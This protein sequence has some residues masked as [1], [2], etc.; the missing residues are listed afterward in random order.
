MT[1]RDNEQIVSPH[2][3]SISTLNM[4][5]TEGRFLLAGSSDATISIYDLSP[6]GRDP[7]LNPYQSGNSVA[8]KSVYKPVA[9]SLRSTSNGPGHSAS[10]VRAEWYAFDTGA[11]VSASS[12]GALVVWDTHEM[13]P[14][15]QWQP[16]PSI[17][18][19]HLSKSSA[20]SESLLAVCSKDDTTVKLVDL[21]SGAAC[22]TLTGH[23]RGVTAVQWCP[24]CDVVLASSSRDGTV[25]LWDIRKAGSRATICTLD[26]EESSPLPL[27]PYRSDI[28]TCRQCRHIVDPSTEFRLR[29]MVNS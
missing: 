27:R 14:V 29:Q 2:R 16:F 3:A 9:Q 15:V 18:S 12:D 19:F 11:F 20:R 22:H 8:P 4:D 5:R 10:I 13:Q 6:W 23:L 26:R 1:L 21:R 25:R 7:L 17:S 24:T 28:K